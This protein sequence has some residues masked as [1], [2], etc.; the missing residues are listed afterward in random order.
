MGQLVEFGLND[1]GTIFVEMHEAA[2]VSGPV[3]RD[4]RGGQ[5]TERARQ[6]FEDAIQRVEPA[7]QAIITQVRGMAQAPDEVQ[8]EFGLDLHAEAGAFIAAASATANFRIA[9]TWRRAEPSSVQSLA[10]TLSEV[11]GHYP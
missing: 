1:G 6:T 3:T 8:V 7:A 10:G 4:L 2:R 9:M 5:V 11:M